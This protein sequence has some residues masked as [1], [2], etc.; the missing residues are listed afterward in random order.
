MSETATLKQATGGV[1]ATDATPGGRQNGSSD[2]SKKRRNG[3]PSLRDRGI[4]E[5]HVLRGETQDAVA[6]EHDCSRQQNGDARFL[7]AAIRAVERMAAVCAEPRA[8]V[9]T[10]RGSDKAKGRHGDEAIGREGD[11][12]K[13]R[14]GDGAAA[15]TV[16]APSPA[17]ASELPVTPHSALRILP[18]ALWS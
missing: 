10:G 18:K 12:A 8:E 16:G 7:N 9:A 2:E 5:R 13:R 14:Q 17:V 15:N 6:A 11:G 3:R 1:Q 4:Y